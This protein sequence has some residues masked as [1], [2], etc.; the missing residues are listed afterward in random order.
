MDEE[1]TQGKV[2]VSGFG[3]NPETADLEFNLTEIL[4]RA[5]NG[6]TKRI[7]G[8]NVRAY[9]MIQ[10]FTEYDNITP[11]QAHQLGKEWANSVLE[12]NHEY[13]IST[14]VDKGHIHNHVIFNSVSAETRKKFRSQPFKTAQLLR[15]KSDKICYENGTTDFLFYF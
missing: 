7:G 10:S 3:V 13:V 15:D 5:T 4:V 12:G 9:H 2:L 14:H 8:S 11:E 6:N 1:K